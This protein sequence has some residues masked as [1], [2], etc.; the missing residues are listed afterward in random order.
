MRVWPWGA[1]HENVPMVVLTGELITFGEFPGPD[2]GAHWLSQLA[3]IG[4]PARLVE[5]CVKWSLAVNTK[6]VFPAAIQRA[7]QLAMTDPKGPVFVSLPLEFL[8][9]DVTIDAPAQAA[10]PTPATADLRGLD[11]LADMLLSATRPVI[12]TEECGR[13]PAAVERL[14]EIS[15]ASFNSGRGEP[16]GAISEFSTHAPRTSVQLPD[17]LDFCWYSQ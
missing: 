16:N 7:C 17:F 11:K 2:L 8:F 13:S 10:I 6:A 14:I 5:R 9:G 1:L 3:D 15:G 4:G 12:V